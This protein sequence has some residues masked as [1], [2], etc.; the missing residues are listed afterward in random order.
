MDKSGAQTVCIATLSLILSI[1]PSL[2]SVS[3]GV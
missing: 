2:R 3:S 1:I